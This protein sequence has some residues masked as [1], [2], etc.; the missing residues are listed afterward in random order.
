MMRISQ[1]DA[2]EIVSNKVDQPHRRGVVQRVLAKEPLRLEVTWD[3]GRTTILTPAGGNLR[4]LDS[5]R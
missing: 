3:D 2:I 1:G 5:P 4:V